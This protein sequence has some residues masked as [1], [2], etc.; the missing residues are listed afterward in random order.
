MP[1]EANH[2]KLTL[3]E[4]VYQMFTGELRPLFFFLWA[5]IWVVQSSRMPLLREATWLWP[6]PTSPSVSVPISHKAPAQ[7]QIPFREG[8]GVCTTRV[9]W[10]RLA[11]AL[12]CVFKVGS[13][14]SF[15][16]VHSDSCF[17][18][19]S[20]TLFFPIKALTQLTALLEGFRARSH[21]AC[22]HSCE[23]LQ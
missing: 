21:T 10:V 8:M 17:H 1:E 15:I 14:H 6:L 19:P 2:W 16:S 13:A 5:L 4:E 23:V 11:E 18:L 3:F 9:D 20:L 7:T 22:Y 12:F